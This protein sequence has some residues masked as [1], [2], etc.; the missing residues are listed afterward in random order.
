VIAA[1]EWPDAAVA[2]AGILLALSI[3]VAVIVSVAST[4]R[5]R[6][7]VQREENYRKLAEDSQIAMSRTATALERAVAELGDLKARTGELERVLKAVE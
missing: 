5:A 1:T 4:L 6:M 3:I 7:S 2:I